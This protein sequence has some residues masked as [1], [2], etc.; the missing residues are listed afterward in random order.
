MT[1]NLGSEYILE[2]KEN[3]DQYVMEELHRTFKPE[4]INRID[5]IIIFK[6][7]TKGVV[8]E[9]LDKIIFDLQKRLEDK[10]ITLELTENAKEYII[11]HAYDE[12]YGA[13]P[14]KRFVQKNIETMLAKEILEDKIK[15]GSH[16]QIDVQ[17]DAFLIK[18]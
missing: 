2:G 16:L 18:E 6:A 13:R 3:S 9:I 17:K 10:K 4:F 7:L 11:E 5:E 8:R 12:R 15:F 14:I 1:S